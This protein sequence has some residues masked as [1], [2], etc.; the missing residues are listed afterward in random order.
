MVD[1]FWPEPTILLSISQISAAAMSE[2][3]P[4]LTLP[5]ATELLNSEYTTNLYIGKHPNAFPLTSVPVADPIE[6]QTVASLTVYL[7][8]S[9]GNVL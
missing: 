6:C 4:D 2:I 1:G 9:G 8:V 3:P 5:E 7:S